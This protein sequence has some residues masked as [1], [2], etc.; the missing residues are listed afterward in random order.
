MVGRYFLSYEKFRKREYMGVIAA[1]NI[2][3]KKLEIKE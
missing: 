3:G 1:L 2:Y